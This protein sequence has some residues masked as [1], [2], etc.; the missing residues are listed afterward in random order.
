MRPVLQVISWQVT[1]DGPPILLPGKSTLAKPPISDK[2]MPSSHANPKYLG[3]QAPHDRIFPL[4]GFIRHL[5]QRNV[6]ASTIQSS[7]CTLKVSDT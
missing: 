4:V 7:Y 6:V 1:E 3:I 5:Y 2:K